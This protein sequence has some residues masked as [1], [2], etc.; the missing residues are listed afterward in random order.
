VASTPAEALGAGAADALG[1]AGAADALLGGGALSTRAALGGTGAGGGGATSGSSSGSGSALT[2]AEATSGT[3]ADADG[4]GGA[5]DA[6]GFAEVAGFTD[7]TGRSDGTGKADAAAAFGALWARASGIPRAPSGS[8][9]DA[10]KASR[11]PQTRAHTHEYDEDLTWDSKLRPRARRL[12]GFPSRGRRT[13][14]SAAEAI[15]KILG[16]G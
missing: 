4:A 10:K 1:A 16:R 5:T 15:A 8:A 9:N 7:V 6:A 13:G 2:A 3:A 12:Q 11:S 14:R